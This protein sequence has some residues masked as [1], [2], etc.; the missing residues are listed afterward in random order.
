MDMFA[1][2][3]KLGNLRE[4]SAVFQQNE[5]IFG[6]DSRYATGISIVAVEEA[7]GY[8]KHGGWCCV[9]CL[10]SSIAEEEADGYC[11]RQLVSQ[12]V[13]VLKVFVYI[14]ATYAMLY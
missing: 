13:C 9:S 2:N 12:L 14:P 4:N 8:D 10:F 1:T 6:E 7:D 3:G 11:T 5:H